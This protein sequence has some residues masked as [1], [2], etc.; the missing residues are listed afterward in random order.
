MLTA[1]RARAWWRILAIV[2]VGVMAL[3]SGTSVA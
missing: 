1:E 3:L 2:M